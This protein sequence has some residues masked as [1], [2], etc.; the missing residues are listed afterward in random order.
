MKVVTAHELANKLLT[1]EDK[2]VEIITRVDGEYVQTKQIVQL[3]SVW[4]FMGTVRIQP[5]DMDALAS[6]AKGMA[7]ATIETTWPKQ[8]DLVPIDPLSPQSL[9]R[10][11]V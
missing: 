7:T 2:P 5:T 8:G 10:A 4:D 9:G 6:N 1:M 3:A 11:G